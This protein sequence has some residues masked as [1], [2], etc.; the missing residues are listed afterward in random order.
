MH[1]STERTIRGRVVESEVFGGVGV[2]FLR[3]LGV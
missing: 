1:P 2:G 3:I